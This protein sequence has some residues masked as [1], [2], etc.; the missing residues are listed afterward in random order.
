MT[1]D[2]DTGA[3]WHREEEER[4]QREDAAIARCRPL[5]RELRQLIHSLKQEPKRDRPE[6]TEF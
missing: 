3:M 5:D 4:L 6:R 2:D 1:E